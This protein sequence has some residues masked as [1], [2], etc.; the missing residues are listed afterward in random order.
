[1]S[2]SQVAQEKAELK[3]E[4]RHLDTLY[5]RNGKS[6]EDDRMFKELC[7]RYLALKGRLEPVKAEASQRRE[8]KVQE[9]KRRSV[10]DEE[11][12]T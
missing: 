10:D 7:Q 9:R 2:D 3:T 1:M 4:L 11:R 12:R 8:S 5:K 6:E